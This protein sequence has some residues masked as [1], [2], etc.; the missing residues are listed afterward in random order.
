[1]YLNFSYLIEYWGFEF[2][3]FYFKVYDVFLVFFCIRYFF[4]EDFGEI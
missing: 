3:L 1:M 4:I 2:G